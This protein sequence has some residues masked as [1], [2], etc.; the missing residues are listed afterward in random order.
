MVQTNMQEMANISLC[1]SFTLLPLGVVK[2]LWWLQFTYYYDYWWFIVSP[3]VYVV[4]DHSFH[5]VAPFLHIHT[6]RQQGHPPACSSP[7]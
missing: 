2:H 1:C 5:G 6:I 3:S 7:W 4:L